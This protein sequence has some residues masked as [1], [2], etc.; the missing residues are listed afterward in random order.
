MTVCDNTRQHRQYPSA[1]ATK[2]W[3]PEVNRVEEITIQSE[4]VSAEEYTDFLKRTDLGSQYPK[5]RFEERIPRLLANASVSLAA[6]DGEGRLVGV[7]LGLTE[8]DPKQK[9]WAS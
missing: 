8:K 2:G 7:L 6:R 3:E 5:E 4:R 1:P 9:M